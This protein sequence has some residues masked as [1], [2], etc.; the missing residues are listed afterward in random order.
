[1]V[2]RVPRP[3]GVMLPRESAIDASFFIA[4][5][6]EIIFI[7]SLCVVRRPLPFLGGDVF[8]I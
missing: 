4:S 3:I 2:A 5:G 6:A 8:L 1:M 7:A